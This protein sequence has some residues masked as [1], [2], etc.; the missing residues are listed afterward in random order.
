MKKGFNGDF[1]VGVA[2]ARI[3]QDLN[4][5]IKKLGRTIVVMI[6]GV[7]ELDSWRAGIARDLFDCKVCRRYLKPIPALSKAVPRQQEKTSQKNI[8]MA[9]DHSDSPNRG[10]RKPVALWT[11]NAALFCTVPT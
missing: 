2:P 7:I 6:V 8:A 1:D 10:S 4:A 9:F 3:G 11:T 5:M